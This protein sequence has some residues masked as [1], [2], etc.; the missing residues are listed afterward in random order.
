NAGNTPTPVA[1][2]A[3]NV[4][5]QIDAAQAALDAAEV[6]SEGRLLYIADG[7]YQHL[8][9]AVSRSLG[10]E[11]SVER[12]VVSL[13]GMPVIMVPQ[14]RFYTEF[15][16]DPGAEDDEGGFAPADD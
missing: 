1:I 3:N 10:N 12:R 14:T 13:D 15:D 9:A 8:K 5:A 2:T 7:P 16:L 11:Q 4:L 6:P